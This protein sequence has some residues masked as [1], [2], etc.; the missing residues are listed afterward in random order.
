MQVVN[1][2]LC[3]T[4]ERSLFGAHIFTNRLLL[5]GVAMEIVLILVIVYTPWGH[6]VFGTTPISSSVW[7]FMLPCAV[8]M[9]L[10]EE[11]RKWVAVRW[12]RKN[13]N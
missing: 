8:G 11:L 7:L 9:L 13:G 5:W 4:P 10:L 1:V 6:L 2:F 3:K 12:D